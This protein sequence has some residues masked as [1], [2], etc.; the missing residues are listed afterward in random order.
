M[1]KRA[2]LLLTKKEVT[3]ALAKY[4]VSL[5]G[6]RVQTL[7]ALVE[8]NMLVGTDKFDLLQMVIAAR[9]FRDKKRSSYDDHRIGAAE[10]QRAKSLIGRDI[11]DIPEVANSERRAACVESFQT[12][13][14]TYGGGTFDLGWS[15][16]H[17]K[18]ITKI[19]RAVVDGELFAMAMPRGSGKTSLCE[20]GAIWSICTGL[21]K[22]I[23][24][25]GADEE[26][27]HQMLDSITTE[28]ETNDMLMEDFPKVCYPIKALDGITGRARGQLYQGKSTGLEW[29]RDTVTMATIPGSDASGAVIKVSGLMGRIRGLKTKNLHGKS[30]RPDLV[31]IDDPQTDG[32]AR[33]ATQ[34]A[35]REKLLAGAVLGLAGPGKKIAGLM[36]V[37]II[38]QDDMADRM[39]NRDMNPEW[40]GEKTQML[41]SRP[42][43]VTLW[44]DYATIRAEGF[45]NGDGIRPATDF[46][47]ANQEEMD[48]GAV[49]AWED[50]YTENEV[51]AIQHAMNL[52]FSDPVAFE[53]EYQNEPLPEHGDAQP[54]LG[55]HEIIEK[56]NGLP[57]L[58][59][60]LE[61][62]HL[63][64]FV[65]VQQACLY[66]TVCAW[67]D[68]FTGSVVAYGAHP[69]QGISY[70]TLRDLNKTLQNQMPD[71]GLEAQLY[72]GMTDLGHKLLGREWIREDGITMKI[73]RCLIDANWGNSTSIVY[74]YCRQSDYAAILTP[75][76]GR[77]VGASNTSM[78]EWKKKPGERM[79]LHWRI[80]A[81]A[82]RRAV[83]HILYD[84]NY[85]KSFVHERLTIPVGDDG[86]LTL[87]GKQ[88]VRHRMF[89]DQLTA[90]FPI[91]VE[92]KN[93]ITDEW[94]IKPSKPD[95]HFLDCLSGCAVAASIQGC[96]LPDMEKEKGARNAPR[97]KLSEKKNKGG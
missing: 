79:G 93:R 47:R 27:A 11:G 56:M 8:G 19:Q 87:Y 13:C 76:H 12:F 46:Y 83:R 51:S 37:T 68:Q 86:S 31:L 91:R 2:V 16:D 78:L 90:E 77:F 34:C 48:K 32:S 50:R 55:A 6:T 43:N 4:G 82:G 39:L 96:V 29:A 80:P 24:L 92:G 81:Q 63:T 17:L 33:S 97:Y 23:V 7:D 41:Y 14:E 53:A 60:P 25:L 65:D 26:A 70:F 49:V 30:Y 42:E 73:E 88:A 57:E 95:N 1:A 59:V 36:A 10:K 15:P 69:D 22:F 54:I 71:A 72:K 5:R 21:R 61:T 94:K 75:S 9:K 38:A 3:K 40:Q 85:W 44:D 20:W 45:R 28:F 35:V 58:T 64:A 52:Y 18:V 66:W 89:A 74:Q 84:S 62:T 67:T